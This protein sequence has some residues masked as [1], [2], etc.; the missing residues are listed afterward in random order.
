MQWQLAVGDDIAARRDTWSSHE[1]TYQYMKERPFWE[2]WDDRVL[3]LY[4]VGSH[5]R[6]HRTEV[7]ELSL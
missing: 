7:R 2:I 3:R 5:L 6:T 4:V 1:D